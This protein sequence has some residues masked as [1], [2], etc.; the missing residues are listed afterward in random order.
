RVERMLK[1]LKSAV[2]VGDGRG[3]EVAEAIGPLRDEIGRVFVHPRRD[4][5]S[6][7]PV[8]ADDAR[9]GQRERE[10][11]QSYTV[12]GT[13]PSRIGTVGS[14]FDEA[15]Q[16]LVHPVLEGRAHAVRG[17]LVDLERRV[18]DQLR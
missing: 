6:L 7:A 4:V 17:A 13:T 11:N 14:P 9:Q 8:P 2:H 18:L 16:L 5:P 12:R 1:F 3:R 15:E 10:D